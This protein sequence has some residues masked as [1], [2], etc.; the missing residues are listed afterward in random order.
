MNARS[1]L[2]LVLWA[3]IA[4]LLFRSCMPKS[5]APSESNLD[6]QAEVFVEP[7]L[8][9]QT[10]VLENQFM[11]SEWSTHGAGCLRIRLKNFNDL[12]VREREATEADWITVFES[13]RGQ[14]PAAESDPTPLHYRRRLGLRLFGGETEL[15]GSLDAMAW[16][17]QEILAENAILFTTT[18]P[19]GVEIS[20]RVALPD[21]RYHFDVQV[22]A[23]A[24]EQ[25]AAGQDLPLRIGTGGGIVR[26]EDSFYPNP[27]VAVGLLDF[28]E[29]D[30][31]DQF[32]PRGSLPG[33]GRRD[34]VSRW[35]G[36]VAFVVEGSK[37]FLSAIQPR[38]DSFRGAVAEQLY[39]EWLRQETLLAGLEPDEQALYLE[40]AGVDYALFKELGRTPEAALVAERMGLDVGTVEPVLLDGRHRQQAL[41]LQEGS[42]RES[43]FWKRAS[44][45]GDFRLHLGQVGDRDSAEFQW[46]V[47]PKDSAVLEDYGFMATIPTYADYGSSFFY[48]IFLTQW[49]APIIMALLAFFNSIVG[50]WGVAIILLT[51]LVR[52]MLMPLNRR[53]QL[54]MAGYQVKMQKVKPLLDQVNKKYAKDPQKKQQATMALYKQ[55]KIAPPL[56]GCLPIFI[57]LFAALRSA[58]PL[59]QQ[60]FMGWI[61]DLSRP[62]ALI[63]FGGPILGFFPFQSVTTLNILP[64][65]MV[66][67]WVAHQRS[68]PKP[69]DPNQAQMQKI[70]TF[71]PILFGIML[72]NYASGLSLYMITSSAIGIFEA[73]VIKKKWP[74][75]GEPSDAATG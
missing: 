57:G 5:D 24:R 16:Q 12:M 17:A 52:G 72:Y 27:Y 67:L 74:V 46:Y 50:N 28:N 51:I 39:D 43:E 47:G 55:H 2:T 19:A 37:Y 38:V 14:A 3:V 58:T 10:L 6:F 29:I 56:G 36:Q 34:S 63:D 8:P 23:V 30:D 75:G 25:G 33:D 13:V 61:H 73:K 21:G 20:K 41:A 54:K 42:F 65:L 15:G 18:T 60:E 31:F 70:M 44:I 68:M 35:K 49:I 71:M 32:Y 66:I 40:V 53:S 11:V 1:L 64:V 62:D 22:G 48:R 9:A 45:A 4:W 59:R 69:A 7:E 26:E